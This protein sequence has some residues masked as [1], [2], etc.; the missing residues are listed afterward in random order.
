MH[1]III[2]DDEA[3]A[4]ANL[5]EA[6]DWPSL[7][8]GSVLH[9]YSMKQ[10]I[11]VFNDNSDIGLMICDIEM[12]RGSGIDLLRWVRANHPDVENIFLTCH[13]DFHFAREAL[14]L[15]SMEYLLKPV[16]FDELAATIGKA[17]GKIERRRRT[18]ERSL[19]GTYWLENRSR[20]EEQF[21]QEVLTGKIENSEENLKSILQQ[22][23]LELDMG[24]SYLPM[25]MEMGDIPEEKRNRLSDRD[26]RLNTLREIVSA[27]FGLNGITLVPLDDSDVILLLDWDSRERYEE[28]DMKIGGRDIIGECD[29]VLGIPVNIYL[30]T[31]V[32]LSGLPGMYRMLADM[33]V[34]NVAADG[35]V[36]MLSSRRNRKPVYERPCLEAWHE[37]ICQGKEKSLAGEIDS[38]LERMV[39]AGNMDSAVLR[40][41]C[42]EFLQLLYRVLSEKQIPVG[43]VLTAGEIEEYY[44]ESSK[45]VT[46]ALPMIRRMGGS[47]ISY[48]SEQN[49][50]LSLVERVKRYVSQNLFNEITRDSLADHIFLNPD[51]MTRVFKRETGDTISEY[52]YREK[53]KL[54]ENMLLHTD[55]SIGEIA[56]KIGYSNFS[57]FSKMFRR[58]SGMNPNEFRQSRKSE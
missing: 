47:V 1:K 21:W 14:S 43:A 24:R 41:F 6:I 25:L 33:A 28:N 50:D 11:S 17:V 2:I 52:I 36:L 23:R 57:H 46:R 12:P 15:G 48:L 54:A 7:K 5:I 27:Y 4:V 39:H 51:Y 58:H 35:E 26:V 8:I 49:E 16:P 19:Y 56:M 29:R 31:P 22:R 42:Q 45:S 32:A 38:Y 20:I 37:L 40:E 34:N 55:L 10:A 9:A 18:D 13:A 53:M 3:Q 30:G 44:E